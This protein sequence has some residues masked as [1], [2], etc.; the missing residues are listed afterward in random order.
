[1]KKRLIAGMALIVAGLMLMVALFWNGM[2]L[3][4]RPSESSYPIR[5]V[6]VS[7]YQGEIDWAKMAEQKIDFAFIKATEGS[8]LIDECFAF[9]WQQA[10]AAGLC[11]GAYHF[12]SYDSS[13]ST[14]AE[15][16]I[17]N[18]PQNEW[19]MPPVIDVEFY[20]DYVKHPPQRERVQAELDTIVRMLTEHYGRSPILYAT[21]KAYDLYIADDYA[22][23]DIWIRD[24]FR[25]PKL[26]DGREWTFWQYSDREQ[27]QGY[28]GE[29]K[30][31]DVNVFFGTKEEFERY[32]NTEC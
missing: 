31:I 7:H 32:I 27:L 16:F 22:Q 24:V 23:C 28:A 10:K 2:I 12:F 6:D 5:G 3:F 17:A 26:S 21:K 29:E 11:V 15:N 14:Q 8:S 1:M 4:N 30:Y 25:K 9:N 13:G 18:V 19:N 20:G